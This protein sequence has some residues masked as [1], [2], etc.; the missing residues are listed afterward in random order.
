[1]RSIVR[2]A[3]L[4]F[5]D[6]TVVQYINTGDDSTTIND[7]EFD[8]MELMRVTYDSQ[9][10]VLGKYVGCIKYID[11]ATLRFVHENGIPD[12]PDFH[13]THVDRYIMYERDIF[14]IVAA[15]I[16]ST[17]CPK[18]SSNGDVCSFCNR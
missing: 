4:D 1:M 10:T 9:V 7:P 8:G 3:L 13:S 12:V 18:C 11:D 2:L 17:S 15:H 16:V 5:L 14:L 6:R